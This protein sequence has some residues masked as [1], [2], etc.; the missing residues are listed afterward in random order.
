MSNQ[1]PNEGDRI[2]EFQT[3]DEDQVSFASAFLLRL[4]TVRSNL[5]NL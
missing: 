5:E 3:L 2:T 1:D 4:A